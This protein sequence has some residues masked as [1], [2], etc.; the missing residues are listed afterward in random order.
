MNLFLLVV[1]LLTSNRVSISRLT[2]PSNSRIKKEIDSAFE[3]LTVQHLKEDQV[4]EEVREYWE[5][6]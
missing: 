2:A 3:K 6:I 1:M 4:I 5:S